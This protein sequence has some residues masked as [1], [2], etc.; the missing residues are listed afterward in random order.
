MIELFFFNFFYN[1]CFNDIIFFD[2]VEVL[3][4][5]IIF[6]FFCNF[7]CIIFKVFKCSNFVFKDNNFVMDNMNVIIMSNFIICYV[8]VGNCIYFGNI[9]CLMNLCLINNFFL[10]FWIKY[11]FY[12]C[13]NFINGFIDNMV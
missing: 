5:D 3:Y 13:F 8:I 1:V 7:F 11:F 2:I 9:D 12:C 10:E 6:V 4:C